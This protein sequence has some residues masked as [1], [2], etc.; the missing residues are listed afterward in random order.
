MS[1][2]GPLLYEKIIS[3]NEDKGFQ[4]RLVVSV[5]KDI[6]YLHIRKYFLSF[7]DGYIPSKEGISIPLT[8]QNSYA[9]LEG[10]AEICSGIE[11]ADCLSKQFK[12][13]M[14]NLDL[15]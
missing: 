14:K 7:E 13:L 4:I 6:E 8:I 3:Q 10:L 9:L 12:E 2:E 11:E 1:D 5:F 15:T